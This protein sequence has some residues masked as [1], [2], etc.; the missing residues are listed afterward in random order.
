MIAYRQI[1][2]LLR[3]LV[4]LGFSLLLAAP[5]VAVE[6]K[7][8]TV[9]A[10][11]K[12]VRLS[13]QRMTSELASGPFLYI[14]ALAPAEREAE[15][16]GLRQGKI[17]IRHL[18]TE[19]QGKSIEVPGGLIHHWVGV[20]FVPGAT[21]RQ[22]LDFLQDYDHQARFFSPDVQKSKLRSRDGNRFK[23][24][25]RLKKTKVVTVFL[26]TDYDVEY[27]PI[28]ATRQVS[29]SRST[30][31]AEIANAGQPNERAKPVGDGAGFMWRL[32][33]YWRFWQKDGGVYVQLEA[34][35]LT[36]DIPAGL[37]WLIRPFVT[38]IPKESIEFTLD[39][40][41]AALKPR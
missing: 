38:S 12:Y 19:E 22:T 39:H 33:S 3:W 5:V 1:A 34:I 2:S 16:A 6:L 17:L 31:I 9:A 20:V 32:N 30:R 11:D 37:G 4:V 24:Y 41:G 10:F 40:T 18:H 35:S 7:P 21:L 25:L 23:V 8:E 36:R 29:S 27:L 15:Y 13:E 28:D 14:D 26:D